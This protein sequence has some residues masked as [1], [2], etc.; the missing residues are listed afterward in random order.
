LRQRAGKG[1]GKKRTQETKQKRKE[2]R[3]LNQGVRLDRE[4]NEEFLF[5]FHI[6]LQHNLGIL[7]NKYYV[8]ESCLTVQLHHERK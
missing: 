2:Q 1:S 4:E 6:Y 5:T 7:A 3:Y 8:F